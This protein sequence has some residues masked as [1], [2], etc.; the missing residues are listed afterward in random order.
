MLRNDVVMLS[1]AEI[2]KVVGAS[3]VVFALL[4]A[5]A[6]A[7]ALRR[8]PRFGAAW[9]RSAAA[10]AAADSAYIFSS[11]NTGSSGDG[12]E[13]T[14]PNSSRVHTGRGGIATHRSRDDVSAEYHPLQRLD[15]LAAAAAAASAD[16]AGECG[17]VPPPVF[18]PSQLPLFSRAERADFCSRV[19]STLHCLVIVPGIVAGAAGT[20]WRGDL[21]AAPGSDIVALQ[22]MLAISAAYF[23]YDFFVIAAFRVP[24]YPVYL[25]H[26]VLALVPICMNLFVPDCRYG[27]TVAV[28]LFLLVEIATVP[29]N[30][31][32]F[33]E[34]AAGHDRSR[35]Y[36]FWLHATVAVW[37]PTRLA[38]PL[39]V[40]VQLITR[41]LPPARAAGDA[42]CLLPGIACAAALTLFCVLV[43]ALLFVPQLAR[44]YRG[45]TAAAGAAA[46]AG[47]G[48]GDTLDAAIGHDGDQPV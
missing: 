23:L 39:W 34:Q 31:M 7:A 30:V 28:G 46:A 40:D 22:L 27:S 1:V 47:A 10:A 19:N 44:R 17:A 2:S 16:D 20:R 13:H 48:P 24:L 21:T 42:W 18:A 35:R 8:H 33:V 26:H 11:V 3:I 36:G 29:V 12:G 14:R 6:W 32:A 4:F 5:A 41:V 9:R 15:P 37:V 45:A 38:L 43:F 25:A